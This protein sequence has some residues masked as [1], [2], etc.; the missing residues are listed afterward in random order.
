MA[1]PTQFD[2]ANVVLGPPEG[3]EDSVVRMP[4]RRMDGTCVSCW[5]FSD[6]EIAEIVRTGRIWLSV[7]GRHTQP[8]VQVAAFEGEVI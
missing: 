3:C 8:P 5:Q 6:E 1:V 2:E 7:W 4:V